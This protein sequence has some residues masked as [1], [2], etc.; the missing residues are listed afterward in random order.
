MPK[1]KPAQ[2]T[3]L[4]VGENYLVESVTSNLYVGRLVDNTLGPHTLVLEDAA[5]IS[6][7][8]RLHIFMRT[9]RADN[10]EVEP[11]GIK[12]VHWAS[13]SPWPFECFKEVVG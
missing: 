10:M 12:C 4:I 7:T 8:G 13:W 2:I 3:S 6:D 11:V 9:G 5:W 1:E